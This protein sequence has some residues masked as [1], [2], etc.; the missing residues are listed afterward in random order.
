L[1]RLISCGSTCCP[2]A[3][4][5]LAASVGASLSSGCL[6]LGGIQSLFS[7]GL[8]MLRG[9]VAT[10]LGS[11]TA[12]LSLGTPFTRGSTTFLRRPLLCLPRVTACLSGSQAI[13][14]S[15]QVLLRRLLVDAALSCAFAVLNALRLRGACVPGA[16]AIATCVRQAHMEAC[17]VGGLLG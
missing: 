17:F 9:R 14:S 11:G 16:V 15:S 12:L 2:D 6:Q 13:T 8:A 10:L 1:L 3:R 5:S 4:P 7:R